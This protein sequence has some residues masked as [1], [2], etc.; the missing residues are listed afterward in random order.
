MT[1]ETEIRR[2]TEADAEGLAAILRGMGKENVG[3]QGTFD[4]DRI[5]AWLGRLGSDGAIFVALDG[6]IPVAFGSLD[7]DTAQPD[8]G[9]L[10]VWV[11]P[12]HRRRGL[13]TDLADELLAF[14][15]EK[16]YRRI[17]GRLPEGNEPALSFLSEI[18]A[19][20]PLRNPSMTFELP[21]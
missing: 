1:R 9:L 4:A 17:R 15:R 6:S 12:D 7:F 3:L 20:V 19:M 10:G 8:T 11:S 18:G 13:A 21:L 5:R 2:A 16:G 14:A